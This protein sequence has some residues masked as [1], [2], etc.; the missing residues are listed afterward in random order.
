[1]HIFCGLTPVGKK[2]Q[3]I[4]VSPQAI[5][6]L[7]INQGL[8]STSAKF[9]Q[10][11][12]EAHVNFQ[13]FTVSTFLKCLFAYGSCSFIFALF[14]LCW[15]NKK[16]RWTISFSKKISLEKKSWNKMMSSISGSMLSKTL[17][18]IFLEAGMWTTNFG[19]KKFNIL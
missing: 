2:F 1:M 16:N 4:R 3:I 8:G 10:Q 17:N 13:R 11:T 12:K 18:Q 15:D 5:F 6:I 9:A 14:V 7:E 19:E